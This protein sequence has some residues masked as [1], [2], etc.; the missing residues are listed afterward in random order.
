VTI[1][2]GNYLGMGCGGCDLRGGICV[3]LTCIAMHGI[4][5]YCIVVLL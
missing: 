3:F 2:M 4:L 5:M 1:V